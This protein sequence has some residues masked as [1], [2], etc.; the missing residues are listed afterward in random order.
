MISKFR[1]NY[2]FL[3]NYYPCKIIYN[4]LQYSTTEHA[5]QS[6][7]SISFTDHERIRNKKTPHESKI[8]GNKIVVREDWDKVKF[9]IMKEV[10]IEK[11]KRPDL[12]ERLLNTGDRIL[13]EGNWWH[14]NIWGSCECETCIKIEGKNWLGKLLMEVREEIRKEK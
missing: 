1:G 4:G 5:Y 6:A 14:D 9:S 7:K 8:E 3:S 12:A 10:L 11:F 2:A 13:V